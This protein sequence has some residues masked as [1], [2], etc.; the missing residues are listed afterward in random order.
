M[1]EVQKFIN[2]PTC[3]SKMDPDAIFC[4]ECGKSRQAE[5][6]AQTYIQ[7]R[8]SS[9]QSFPPNLVRAVKRRYKDGYLYARAINGYGIIIKGTGLTIGII[10][11]VIGVVIGGG[12]ADQAQRSPFGPGPGI[13]V[14]AG[15]VFIMVAVIVTVIFWVSGVITKAGAQMLK[16]SLDGAVYA[17]PFLT[18]FDRAEIMSL[19]TS[20][21]EKKTSELESIEIGGNNDYDSAML[22]NIKAALTYGGSFILGVLWLPVPIYVVATTPPEQEFVRFHAFQSIILTVVLAGFGFVVTLL[23]GPF[24]IIYLLISVSANLL[25]L[26]KAYNNEEFRIPL[27]GDLALNFAGKFSDRTAF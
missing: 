2:C 15:A 4:N 7:T 11:S 14:G 9:E 5:A 6:V 16:A 18:D 24:W 3:Y 13:G 21:Y 25:C 17:S 12:I 23:L 27:I 22:P 20:S 8:I 26:W 19:P 1:T 10:I